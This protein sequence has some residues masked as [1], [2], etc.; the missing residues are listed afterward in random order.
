MNF[1][2]TQ[3]GKE[4]KDQEVFINNCNPAVVIREDNTV[5]RLMRLLKYSKS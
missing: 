1:C 5:K 2:E 3:S 4:K